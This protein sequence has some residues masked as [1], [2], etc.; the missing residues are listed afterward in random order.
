[1]QTSIFLAKLMGPV[2]LAMGAGMLLNGAIF[3]P[4]A[5]QYLSSY[6]FIYISGLL[7]LPLGIAILLAH[8][9]WAPDWRVLITL[10]GWVMM[11]GGVFRIVYPQ[12]VQRFG[13]ALFHL[14]AAPPAGGTVLVVLG[15]T[16]SFFGF[17]NK[18]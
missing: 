16:L 1:M 17:R 7:A 9:V 18:V 8:N 11:I 13:G 10:L 2:F 12:L 15:A 3:H 6:A 4:M 5:E 14:S